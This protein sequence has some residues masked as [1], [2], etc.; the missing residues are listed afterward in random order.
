MPLGAYFLSTV[1]TFEAVAEGGPDVN[2]NPGTWVQWG[3]HALTTGMT[4]KQLPPGFK[5][6]PPSTSSC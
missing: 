1:D 5:P 2:W 6:K 3:V 4:H